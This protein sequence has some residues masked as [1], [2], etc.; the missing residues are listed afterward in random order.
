[1]RTFSALR[2][3]V[4]LLALALAAPAFAQAGDVREGERLFRA[5]A[6]CHSLESG[7]HMTGPSLAGIFGREAGT[8]EGF[9]RYSQELRESGIVWDE[10]TMDVWLTDPA[11]MVPG[12][13]MAFPGVADPQARTDVI[14]F[15]RE[16]AEA[17]APNRAEEPRRGGGMMGGME[18]GRMPDLSEVGPEQQVATV[19]YCGDTYQVT[20]A[21]GDTLPIWEFNLRIKTDS[22]DR[23]PPEGRPAL[24]AAGMMGDRYSLIF[25]GP[26][27]ISGFVKEEC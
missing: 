1:M 17:G 27:E 15:L 23:G 20:T 21:A 25:A 22:S 6:A 11:A 18:G 24:L 8:A 9:N 14:A 16:A 5:C 26:Q 13:R 10:A 4:L 7:R 12:N 3:A 2:G 19:R